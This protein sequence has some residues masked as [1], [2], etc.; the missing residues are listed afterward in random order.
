MRLLFL[1]VSLHAN[2][3]YCALYSGVLCGVSGCTIFFPTLN[4]NRYDFR[5]C[6]FWFSLQLF[7]ETFLNLRII[8]QLSLICTGLHVKF[9]LFL[10][11]FNQ[12]WIFS[13]NVWKILKYQHL[14]K[15]ISSSSV[16]PR[17]VGRHT[18]MTNLTVTFC[19]IVSAPKNTWYY[20]VLNPGHSALLQI[21]S[22]PLSP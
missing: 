7:S 1:P 9:L 21:V 20:W 22:W 4:H 2:R 3:I 16:V 18:D 12:S 6:M 10:L 13:T 11:D 14:I 5:I 15:S 17:Q 19:N 8:K